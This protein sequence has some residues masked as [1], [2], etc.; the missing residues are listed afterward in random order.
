MNFSRL[1]LK[2]PIATLLLWI[3]VIVAGVASWTQLPIAALPKYETPVIEVKGVLSGASP[4]TM[5][6]SIA[7]PLE[8]EFSSIAGLVRTSSTSIQ[9]ETK[10]QLEFDES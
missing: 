3:S 2:R 6:S 1:F 10:I 9:A 4:E 8:K 5:A 7:T